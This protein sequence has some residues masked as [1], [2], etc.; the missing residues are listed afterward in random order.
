MLTFL[1]FKAKRQKLITRISP[2][3]CR[4]NLMAQNLF[5]LFRTYL[6]KQSNLYNRFKWNVRASHQFCNLFLFLLWHLIY[7]RSYFQHPQFTINEKSSQS[8]CFC[9]SKAHGIQESSKS[10]RWLLNNIFHILTGEK[11]PIQGN[12]ELPHRIKSS[13]VVNFRIQILEWEKSLQHQ[14]IC[15]LRILTDWLIDYMN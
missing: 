1:Y 15:L 5:Y 3:Y 4:R 11:G 13:L 6:I 10:Q 7:Y 9:I 2:G 8:K 14:R 12:A